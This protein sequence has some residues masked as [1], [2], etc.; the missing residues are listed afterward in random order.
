MGSLHHFTKK[1]KTPLYRKVYHCLKPDGEFYHFDTPLTVEHEIQALQEAG[2][3][4]V[5]ILNR[6]GA[7]YAL[8]AG[9]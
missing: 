2:F 6:R 7:T 4:T 5:K 3:P 9:K 1:E 8:K